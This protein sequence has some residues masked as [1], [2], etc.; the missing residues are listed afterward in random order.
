[1]VGSTMTNRMTPASSSPTP[2]LGPLNRPVHPSTEVR[3]GSTVLRKTGA[4]TISPH[5]P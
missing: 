1:M 2:S 4:S 3:K 5:S